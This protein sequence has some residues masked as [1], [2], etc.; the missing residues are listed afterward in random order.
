MKERK[1]KAWSSECKEKGIGKEEEKTKTLE[2]KM[3]RG[4]IKRKVERWRKMRREIT[5]HLQWREK[6]KEEKLR[7]QERTGDRGVKRKK[8]KK[9]PVEVNGKKG[10]NKS[11][12]KIISGERKRE[13]GI[14]FYMQSEKLQEKMR[15]L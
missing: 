14:K 2:N 7:R 4:N 8:K 6:G 12:A 13:E 11:K 3:S 1:E 9:N 15:G 5:P 10:K